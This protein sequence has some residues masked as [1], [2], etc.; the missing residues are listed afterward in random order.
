MTS[1]YPINEDFRA[2][3][4]RV[5]ATTEPMHEK[6]RVAFTDEI[7][8]Q[9]AEAMGDIL[10]AAGLPLPDDKSIMQGAAGILLALDDY[11]FVMRLEK[12]DNS[13][14]NSGRVDGHPLVL[15]PLKSQIL[16]DA[17][18]LEIC[19]GVHIV[20]GHGLVDD[21]YSRHLRKCGIDFWDAQNANT[22]ILLL[23]GTRVVIDRPA[24]RQLRQTPDAIRKAWRKAGKNTQKALYKD[25]RNAMKK[26][27]PDGQALPDRDKFQ[28][29]LQLCRAKKV[30][31]VLVSGW[32]RKPQA[33][34]S[35][36]RLERHKRDALADAG[37]SY[38]THIRLK[39]LG[40]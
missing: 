5:V 34:A 17:A 4:Q 11:G 31:G 33:T 24:A 14:V 6:L 27:W 10:A 9:V 29:F 25:L 7:S 13:V 37:K 21:Q 40:F 38:A 3:A 39:E 22:G 20:E 36:H 15:Q 2:V 1:F 26:A 16:C 28:S 18:V 12:A 19:P 8:R 23:A 32:Q 35:Q 30:E